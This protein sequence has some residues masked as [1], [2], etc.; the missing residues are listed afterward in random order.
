MENA[1]PL[2]L[3]GLNEACLVSLALEMRLPAYRGR[4]IYHSIYAR[5]IFDFSQM[6][7]LPV[8]LQRELAGKYCMEL[9]SLHSERRSADGTIK[10]LLSLQDG[11]KI[12]CVYIPER[13]RGTLCISSQVGCAVGCTFC[14]TATLGL[15]RNLMAGEIV[16][17]LL[18]VSAAEILR[19]PALNIVMMGMGEPLHNFEAVLQA[20][21]LLCD[22]AGMAIS[23]R[24]ITLSTSGV[25][26]GLRRLAGQPLIPN[27]AISLNAANDRTRSEIMPINR[28]WNIE[29]LLDACRQF[30]ADSRRRITFEY[31]LLRGVN[32]SPEDASQLARLLRGMAAKVNLIAWNANPDLGFESPGTESV[33]RFKGILEAAGISAFLRKPRGL[34]IYA[35]CGQLALRS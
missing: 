8:S 21:Q 10:M 29:A 13:S 19:P 33:A 14:A 7:D 27:L 6:T 23:Q 20:L 9:P 3:I 28:R 5:K 31:V 2:N 34:D 24:R 4:Q 1:R 25:V 22:P 26:S 11:E 32:D 15:R 35:A 12:E 30:P 16:S 18:F 17:Q